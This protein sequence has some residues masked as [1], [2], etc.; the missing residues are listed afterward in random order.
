MTPD[1]GDAHDR[2]VLGRPSGQQGDESVL[3]VGFLL[4]STHTQ[5]WVVELLDAARAEPALRI[6]PIL[7]ADCRAP[8][9]GLPAAVYRRLDR[10]LFSS[11]RDPWSPAQLDES[12]VV[13]DAAAD[14]PEPGEIDVL[15][16]LG[17]SRP[18]NETQRTT[19][20]VWWIDWGPEPS[21]LSTVGR[22]ATTSCA[23]LVSKDARADAQIVE[24]IVAQADSASW[25][26]TRSAAHD[27]TA[28]ALL[29]HL[30]LR[31]RSG[32]PR[33]GRGALTETATAHVSGRP[34]FLG[35]ASLLVSRR[36]RRWRYETQWLIAIRRRDEHA[37]ALSDTTRYRVCR[38]T[39]GHSYADP[40]LASTDDGRSFV[41]FEDLPPGRRR[42]VISCSE[43]DRDG[44]LSS[45]EV[46]LARD[47]H[48]SY[49]LVF[50][51]GDDW[52]MLPETSEHRTIE[53]YRA[54]EFPTRWELAR[55]LAANV[56][57]L[58]TTP[59]VVDDVTWIFSS[60]A[61]GSARQTD[62]VSLFWCESLDSEW[63]HHPA[64]P[65]VTDIRRSRSAGRIFERGGRLYRPSQDGSRRYGYALT[66]NEITRLTEDDYQEQ[67][68]SRIEPHWIE[69]G[70]C[71]HH[72]D[73]SGEF[74]VIDAQV[75]R[76]KRRT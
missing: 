35:V 74:E 40:F 24:T 31:A 51:D 5:S 28:A 42:A 26:R 63:H 27:R 17:R 49:P 22:R 76:R 73:A 23:H 64:N 43:V 25:V 62:M 10:L 6:G 36:T 11:D 20:A 9:L 56:I 33:E 59:V 67:P 69:G 18:T 52:Y 12:W 15:V 3:R 68:A 58:D 71:T 13:E 47:Y 60:L 61:R 66:F 50:R 75:R 4:D 32:G 37:T 14:E 57:A 2:D 7:V 21:F 19:G 46:V 29:R 38:P 34:S 70:I 1:E 65:V 54:V 44:C 55:T 16:C 45:P 48:L 8:R 30:R 72:Y 53:L 39:N 41:F